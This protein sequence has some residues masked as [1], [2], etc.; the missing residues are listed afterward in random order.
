MQGPGRRRRVS[1]RGQPLRAAIE[2]AA[3][4]GKRDDG[5]VVLDLSHNHRGKS[6]PLRVWPPPALFAVFQVVSLSFAGNELA[7]AGDA[8]GVWVALSASLRTLDAS[9]CGLRSLRGLDV[10]RGLRT[11]DLSGNELA[12]LPELP[13]QLECLDVSGNALRNLAEVVDALRPLENSLNRFI[14]RGNPLCAALKHWRSVLVVALFSRRRSDDAR[15]LSRVFFVDDRPVTDADVAAAERALRPR[16]DKEEDQQD[17]SQEVAELRAQ[18][19][20]LESLLNHAAQLNSE[21][22]ADLAAARASNDALRRDVQEPRFVAVSEKT[23]SP[24]PRRRLRVVDEV[25]PPPPRTPEIGRSVEAERATLRAAKRRLGVARGRLFLLVGFLAEVDALLGDEDGVAYDDCDAVARGLAA[26]DD[27][28][29]PLVRYVRESDA[30]YRRRVAGRVEVAKRVEEQQCATVQ[31]LKERLRRLEDRL[32]SLDVTTPTKRTTSPRTRTTT[33]AAPAEQKTP[34]RLRRASRTS[35]VLPSAL[36]SPLST[37]PSSPDRNEEKT[38]FEA[39]ETSPPRDDRSED[40]N[41]RPSERAA[42][43]P[44]APVAEEVCAAKDDDEIRTEWRGKPPAAPVADCDFVLGEDAT[45]ARALE[46][47]GRE[48]A[49]QLRVRLARLEADRQRARGKLSRLEVTV[50]RGRDL[51][52]MKR[53]TQSADT[54]VLVAS[55]VGEVSHLRKTQVERATRY[56]EWRCSLQLPS[57]GGVVEFVVVDEPRVGKRRDVVVGRARLRLDRHQRRVHRWL[58]LHA[59]DD[60]DARALPARAAISVEV[61]LIHDPR[62]LLDRAVAVLEHVLAVKEDEPRN[63]RHPPPPRDESSAEERSPRSSDERTTTPRS[64]ASFRRRNP[65][66]GAVNLQDIFRAPP[67]RP[68]AADSVVSSSD[69]NTTRPPWKP[70]SATSPTKRRGLAGQHRRW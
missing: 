16:P 66:E 55:R 15:V 44:A 4:R 9:R 54:F 58:R 64:S 22:A 34:V 67:Q 2:E 21:T 27:P 35:S 1:F 24:P 10:L 63:D 48:S 18:N 59:D 43:T 5:T 41:D 65:S 3:E 60:D 29:E 40:Q 31:A 13:A 14:L 49:E 20:A 56:P 39:D 42:E 68:S 45:G 23:P 62:A 28:D 6:Q 53:E 33:F 47:L 11:L 37:A 12:A 61:R 8:R 50:V 32:S 57:D 19:E 30:A 51:P 52:A 17:R 36:P 46:L 38:H 7:A 69:N 70:A 26:L 25:S